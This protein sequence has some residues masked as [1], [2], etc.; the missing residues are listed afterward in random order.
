MVNVLVVHHDPDVADEQADSLRRAGYSV[1]Q[2]AGPTH[3]PCPI[4]H[5]RPCAA[6]ER[7]DVLVYDVWSAGD[8]EDARVLIERL[9]EQHPEVPVVLDAPGMEFDWVRADGPHAVVTLV[10][11]PSGAGLRAAVA[12]ALASVGSD[13]AAH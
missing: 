6:V 10:G 2:C 12:Q 9:R 3:G 11:Q 4:L 13:S 7:A 1:E 5:D 8:S